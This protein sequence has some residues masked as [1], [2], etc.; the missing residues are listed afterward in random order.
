M[1]LAK[2]TYTANQTGAIACL[3]AVALGA[4]L[5][6]GMA[7]TYWHI[8]ISVLISLIILTALAWIFAPIYAKRIKWGYFGGIIIVIIALVAMLVPPVTQPLYTF[9]NPV[10]HFS[11]VTFLLVHLA[12]LYFSYAS[13]KELG[14]KRE[15][16]IAEEDLVRVIKKIKNKKTKKKS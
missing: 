5:T 2:A 9:F 12:L 16:E 3:F 11:M 13:F 8:P 1:P 10:F 15:I 7:I 14:H 6:I 4:L